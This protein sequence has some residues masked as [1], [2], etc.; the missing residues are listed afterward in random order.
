MG[1]YKRYD[2][3]RSFQYLTAGRDYRLFELCPELGRVEPFQVPLTVDEEV[4]VKDLLENIILI[5][6]HEHLGVFPNDVKETPAYVKGG[7]YG[8][9]LRGSSC[10]LLGW[11]F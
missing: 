1:L 8:Y 10:L 2:G 5:S 11:G 9:G 6:L 4:R 3:Y 7:S